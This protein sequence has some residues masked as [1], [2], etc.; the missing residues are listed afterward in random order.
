MTALAGG[1]AVA[2]APRIGEVTGR[3]PGEARYARSTLRLSLIAC[4][5]ALGV[6]VLTSLG[7]WQLERR[8]SADR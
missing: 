8:V 4:F 5:A 6:A 3:P 1:K 7:A 2:A